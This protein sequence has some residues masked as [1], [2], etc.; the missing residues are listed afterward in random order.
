MYFHWCKLCHTQYYDCMFLTQACYQL[1][2]RILCFCAVWFPTWLGP[3]TSVLALLLGWA[4]VSRCKLWTTEQFVRLQ[5]RSCYTCA[6][7]ARKIYLHV[8]YSSFCT[9]LSMYTASVFWLICECADVSTVYKSS[10]KLKKTNK[11]KADF[12]LMLCYYSQ[13]NELTGPS[14]TTRHKSASLVRLPKPFRDDPARNI[15]APGWETASF[16]ME[17]IRLCGTVEHSG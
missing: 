15:R 16:K 9:R 12:R 2:P 17:F 6:L 10:N 11:R 7:S 3:W 8:L 14:W 13:I 4:E 5:P 1:R